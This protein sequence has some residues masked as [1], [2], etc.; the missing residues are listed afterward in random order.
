MLV[1]IKFAPLRLVSVLNLASTQIRGRRCTDRDGIGFTDKTGPS[2][3]GPPT[4]T[5]TTRTFPCWWMNR[6]GFR[7]SKSRWIQLLLLTCSLLLFCASSLVCA[8]AAMPFSQ[9][10]VIRAH[11]EGM[12][13]IQSPIMGTKPAAVRSCLQSTISEHLVSSLSPSPM[14]ADSCCSPLPLRGS[15]C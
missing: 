10:A 6:S 11:R 14:T 15:C 13:A 8:A 3:M 7:F 5:T 1:K 2:D 4:T 9:C 12:Y